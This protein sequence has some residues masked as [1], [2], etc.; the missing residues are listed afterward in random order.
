LRSCA[1]EIGY[2]CWDKPGE[3]S[4]LGERLRD[5]AASFPQAAG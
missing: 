2:E 4:I 3:G 5:L 1:T